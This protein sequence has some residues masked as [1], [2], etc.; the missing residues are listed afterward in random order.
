MKNQN[1]PTLWNDTGFRPLTEL[2]REMDRLFDDFGTSPSTMRQV[3]NDTKVIPACD[4]EEEG[5]H[6]LLTIE[7]PGISKNDVK[8]EVVDNQITVSGER[9]LERKNTAGGAWYSERKFG[10][11][12][13][14]FSILVGVSAEKIEAHYQDGILKL[15]VPKAESSKPR[16]I[17][18]SDGR[19]GGFFD[20][21]LN[22]SKNDKEDLRPPEPNRR[23]ERVA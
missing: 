18:I 7:M 2:R 23:N 15:M 11:F 13:R 8:V 16:Q 10:S 14:S 5:D 6:Y 12:Q 22:Q 9:R 21:L 4:V 1:W 3:Q 17:K 20:K 19:S